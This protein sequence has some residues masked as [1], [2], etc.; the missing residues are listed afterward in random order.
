MLRYA[1]DDGHAPARY[2]YG[3]ALTEGL[4]GEEMVDVSFIQDDSVL[5]MFLPSE[6]M[7][8]T[9]GLLAKLD[10]EIA[11]K[12]AECRD[13]ADPNRDID[14]QFEKVADFLDYIR[15]LVEADE[16]FERKHSELTAD[17]EQAKKDVEAKK[18]DEE[19]EDSFFN[20]VP[21]AVQR[22]QEG[23]RS[24]FSDVDE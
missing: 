15:Y 21:R 12:I 4:R 22:E 1:S 13:Q 23:G 7:H 11:E 17:L 20:T 14:N 10:S 3:L 19:D 16:V 9:A 5:A 2:A 24:V 6:L 8:L 18:S